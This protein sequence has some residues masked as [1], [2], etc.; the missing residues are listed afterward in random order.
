MIDLDVHVVSDVRHDISNAR[1]SAIIS[2]PGGRIQ[3]EWMGDVVADS[4][5]RVGHI[6][7]EVPVTVGT[8][9]VHLGLQAGEHTASNHYSTTVTA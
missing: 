9:D 4:C 1:V 2:W 5:A 7:I 8:L 3:R 6:R